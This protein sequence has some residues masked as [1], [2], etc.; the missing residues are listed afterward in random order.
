MLLN[1]EGLA[2]MVA[3]WVVFRES[4]DRRLLIGAASILAGVV[5]LSWQ[6]ETRSL[7]YGALAIVLAC[8]W[9]IDNNLT[10]KL[11]PVDPT[12]AFDQAGAH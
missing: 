7:G 2:T 8:P 5:V 6:G 11:S 10:R 3:A 12:S 9:G 4:V 1:V